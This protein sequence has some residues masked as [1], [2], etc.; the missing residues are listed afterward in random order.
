MMAG[1]QLNARLC[2]FCL[3]G[4]S[5]SFEGRVGSSVAEGQKVHLVRNPDG[6]GQCCICFQAFARYRNG[7][8]HLLL[9]HKI[10]VEKIII[11]GPIL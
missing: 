5:N 1:I 10:P 2:N 4:D 6:S 7:K 11:V 8:R 3:A 9:K